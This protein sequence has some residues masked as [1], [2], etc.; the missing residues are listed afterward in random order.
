MCYRWCIRRSD[1]LTSPA[2]AGE[3]EVNCAP[4]AGDDSYLCLSVVMQMSNPKALVFF[5]ALVPQFLN[6]HANLVPQVAI[7][8]L[9]SMAIEI[10]VQLSYA[11][12]AGRF[13]HLALRPHFARI[14]S[15]VAGSLL[16]VAG[17][18]MA[19]IRRT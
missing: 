11:A 9:T 7:L 6:P 17:I 4:L 10:A 19:A 5:S 12:L 14:T 1:D 8:A 18:G 13:T 3:G 16:V 2:G 15:R